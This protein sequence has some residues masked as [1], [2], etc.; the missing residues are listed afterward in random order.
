MKALYRPTVVVVFCLVL[1]VAAFGQGKFR[2]GSLMVGASATSGVLELGSSAMYDSSG[3]EVPDSKTKLFGFGLNAQIGYFLINGL[4]IGPAVQATY[5]DISSADVSNDYEKDTSIGVGVQ[6]C[7]FLDL[8]RFAL[9]GAV[10]AL[11]KSDTTEI[12]S[13]GPA[14]TTATRTG[15]QII[16]EAGF[17]LFLTD[18]VAGQIGGFFSYS[19]LGDS[20]S[21][22]RAISY[23]VKVGVGVFL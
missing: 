11:Y 4:E 1:D 12:A 6:A 17:A 3:N 8:G 2:S 13:S 14:Y 16:P 5:R 7:Y 18:K 15:F 19:S 10:V 21:N 22:T 9:Y 20:S 23:G